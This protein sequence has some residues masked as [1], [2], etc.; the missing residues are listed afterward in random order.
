MYFFRYASL[1]QQLRERALT[2]RQALPY[3][4]GTGI[5][6]GIS[7][8]INT[9][10]DANAYDSLNEYLNITVFIIGTCYAYAENGGQSGFDFIQK[11][12]VIG[13]IVTWRFI[14]VY[15]GVPFLGNIKEGQ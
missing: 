3:L 2:Q 10:Y 9:N 12:I 13:W 7:N 11:Y 5:L 14:P 15:I 6:I 4:I 1:K 8:L